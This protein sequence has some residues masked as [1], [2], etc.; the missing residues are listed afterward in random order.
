MKSLFGRRSAIVTVVIAAALILS[1]CSKSV[2]DSAGGAS[3][4]CGSYAIA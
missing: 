3:G 2:N 1:G 4:D